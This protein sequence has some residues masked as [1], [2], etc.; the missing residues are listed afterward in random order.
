MLRSPHPFINQKIPLH[1]AE[2][3]I[4]HTR[5]HTYQLCPSTYFSP[6][7]RRTENIVKRLPSLMKTAA[8]RR[9]VH[10]PVR[11][12]LYF[13]IEFAS[14]GDKLLGGWAAAAAFPFQFS[15][16]RF[17][18]LLF[19]FSFLSWQTC[20]FSFSHSIFWNLVNFLCFVTFFVIL[21]LF[22]SRFSLKFYAVW[23]KL[24]RTPVGIF[25]R[26]HFS[27]LNRRRFVL[28]YKFYRICRVENWR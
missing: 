13:C 25:G 11:T 2:P 19:V 28:N 5:T 21:W 26:T 4:N 3:T 6:R 10:F 22:R 23:W 12:R 9:R 15:L 20:H 18:S 16:L 27:S 7:H 8:N 1:R 17:S 24:V 14:L